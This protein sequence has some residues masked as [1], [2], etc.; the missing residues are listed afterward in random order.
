METKWKEIPIRR[1]FTEIQKLFEII[2]P[3]NCHI[4]GGYARYCLSPQ[5]NPSPTS[6]VD[7][8]A[9]NQDAFDNVLKKFIEL[10]FNTLHTNDVSTV[11][12]PS[13]DDFLAC[14][15]INLIVP[16]EEFRVRTQGSI[17]EVLNNFDFTV[18]RAAVKTNTTGIVD[19]DFID[20]EMKQKLVIKNIH[21]PVSSAMRFMKYY[22]K[23]YFTRPMQVLKLFQDWDARGQEYRD[24]LT[25]MI[26][27]VENLL[28][29]KEQLKEVQSN[30]GDITTIGQISLNDKTLEILD[31]EDEDIMQQIETERTRITQELYR[32]M[33]ID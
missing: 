1:G 24:K 4:C 17:E 25:K 10:D 6:D 31:L 23:G 11:F 15:K 8:Y 9:E 32:I 5:R 3:F 12:M 2:T 7:I 33:M 22:K 28:E 20:H 29:K 16:R 18:C 21:C 14:P 13:G 30:N 27:E 26:E 19:E